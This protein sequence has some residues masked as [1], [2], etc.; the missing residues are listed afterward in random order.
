[1]RSDWPPSTRCAA[2]KRREELLG[3]LASYLRISLEARTPR[4]H[5]LACAVG[6]LADCSGATV[7]DLRDLGVRGMPTKP[8]VHRTSGAM[9][10]LSCG[11]HLVACGLVSRAG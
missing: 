9:S 2:A 5:V 8:M 3:D 11:T 6:K 1:V 10:Y 4:L 7:E